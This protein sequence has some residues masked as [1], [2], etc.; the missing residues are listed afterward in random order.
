MKNKHNKTLLTQWMSTTMFPEVIRKDMIADSEKN[1]VSLFHKAAK[2]VPAYKDFLN[3]QECNPRHIITIQDW[4]RV[5]V[6]SKEN[7]IDEYSAKDRTWT[8]SFDAMHMISTSSGT[9][10]T[11]HFWPRDLQTEIEGAAMHEYILKTRYHIDQK[12]TLLINGFAM[13]NWI[14]GTFTLACST[15]LSWK[16]YPLTIM[17]PGYIA[18]EIIPLLF[19]FYDSFDQIIITGHSPFLK[20][21]VEKADQMGFP[22][23]ESSV[24]LLGSGQGITENWRTYIC[25]IMQTNE[26]E[27]TFTNLYGSADAAL[28]GFETTD[29]ISFRRRIE[30]GDRTEL[31]KMFGD[32]RLPSL[33]AYD[34]RYIYFEEIE[35]ELTITKNSGCPLIRYNIEDK[36]GILSN[37]L[38]GPQLP[39]LY[40]F[41]REK[42]M[43]KIYGANIY[44]EHVQNA[45]NSTHLQDY[46]TGRF[47]MEI[48][49]NERED[50]QLFLRVEL[51]DKGE[52][53]VAFENI[54]LET[55]IQEVSK[56]NS[57][58]R[59]VLGRMGDR[60][61]PSIYLHA[62]GDSQYFPKDKVIKTA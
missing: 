34:P 23:T 41:G 40:L 59:D 36:G 58:Y 31:L 56:Q 50:Q 53:P 35:R 6:T 44:S 13:G 47:L 37:R 51:K 24:K 5:P 25:G 62:H 52:V 26:Y 43:V 42:F 1:A 18:E 22:W 49:H 8:G 28:M 7:Y 11:S 10:G 30:N 29:T 14:A 45:I 27:N 39:I 3:K 20:E 15:L 16:G 4:T 32:T 2:E 17:T 38:N 57:E 33:Y 12:K 46:V 60:V 54:I 21:I 48:K 9:S 61:K 55:F 19:Q